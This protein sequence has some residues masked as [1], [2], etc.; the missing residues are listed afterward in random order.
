MV[1]ATSSMI[2]RSLA[3]HPREELIRSA[4]GSFRACPDVIWGQSSAYSVAELFPRNNHARGTAILEMRLERSSVCG[5][6]RNAVF[7]VPVPELCVQWFRGGALE[8]EAIS[9]VHRGLGAAHV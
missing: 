3:S 9:L 5:G 1:S 8:P 4:I 2:S 7:E 6:G